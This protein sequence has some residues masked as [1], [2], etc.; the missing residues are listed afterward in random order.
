LRYELP[1]THGM[2]AFEVDDKY[3][4]GQFFSVNN[5]P[6]LGQ[7]S[8]SIA[9]VRVSL[10]SRSESLTLTAF[11]RNVGNRSYLVGAY[12]LSTY[13]FDEYV[14]GDPRTYGVS[15]LYRVR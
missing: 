12:D 4:S 11:G 8:Y 9:N 14:P 13:G 15:V 6:L 10:T 3:Q 2:L 5:D 1:V 7:R